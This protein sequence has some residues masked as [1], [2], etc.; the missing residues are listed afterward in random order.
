MNVIQQHTMDRV[1]RMI[2]TMDRQACKTHLRRLRHPALPL[3]DDYLESLSDERL[4]YMLLSAY[5]QM[6]RGRQRQAG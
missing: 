2:Q 1:V 3:E 4:R 6:R 5:L